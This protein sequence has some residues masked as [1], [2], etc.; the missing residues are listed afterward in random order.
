MQER[1]GQERPGKG[2]GG[3]LD[4][5]PNYQRRRRRL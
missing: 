2:K 3:R 5:P 1:T 4:N